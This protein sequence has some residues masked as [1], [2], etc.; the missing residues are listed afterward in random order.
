MAV[1]MMDVAKRAG[2]SVTTVSHVMN[3]TREIAPATRERV[4]AAIQELN[5]YKN[6]SARLL[7]R[8][9]SDTIGLI[10]SDIEN[11]FLPEL[12]K[13]FDRA[14]SSAGMEILLGM[15]NYQ[16]QK[17]EAAVRRMIES[18]VRGVAVMTSQ[19]DG[20]LIDQLVQAEI[21]VVV[22]DAPKA[23]RLRGVLSIDYSAGLA[24]AIDHLYRLGHS[25]IGILHGPLHVVSVTR[26]FELVREAI[27]EYGMK[28]SRT[29][30]GDGGPESGA[31]GVQALLAMKKPPTAILCGN[32]LT[33]VGALGMAAK[34]GKSVPRDLSI[35]GCDD[36]AMASYSQPTL[37]TVRIPRDAMGHEAFRLLDKMV[38]SKTRRGGEAVVATSFIVR[39]SSGVSPQA[40]RHPR[41]SIVGS[42]RQVPLPANQSL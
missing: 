17:A 37:S 32:D 6:N 27:A 40:R 22:L 33:A 12:V 19:I 35:V 26:Y 18:R 3:Q 15:T 2:V 14:S 30:E 7:V 25:E 5:Y 8:G 20:R 34:M 41:K 16:Q 9:H 42:A 4:V 13:S 36:I 23:G 21:P 28:L 1:L 24:P 10:I 31:R 11:P 29:I 39:G 38:N